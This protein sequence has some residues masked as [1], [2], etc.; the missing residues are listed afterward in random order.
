LILINATEL[1]DNDIFWITEIYLINSIALEII[2]E[3]LDI[4]GEPQGL[5]KYID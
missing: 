4:T 1:D 3:I 5:A 2:D